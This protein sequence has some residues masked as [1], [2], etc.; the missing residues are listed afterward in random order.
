MTEDDQGVV[1]S[2]WKEAME[3]A[4]ANISKGLDQ[5]RMELDTSR[6][7]SSVP[8]ILCDDIRLDKSSE[9]G[10]SMSTEQEPESFETSVYYQIPHRELL[11]LAA[12]A[13]TVCNIFRFKQR[14]PRK[15]I[16]TPRSERSGNRAGGVNT[17][18]PN[19]GKLIPFEPQLLPLDV[20]GYDE[21]LESG[22]SMAKQGMKGLKH[23]QRIGVSQFPRH[24]M[25]QGGHRH[26]KGVFQSGPGGKATLSEAQQQL[27]KQNLKARSGSS[28]SNRWL[29]PKPTE[30][31]FSLGNIR[32][33]N[34]NAVASNDNT[35]SAASNKSLSQMVRELHLKKLGSPRSTDDVMN[36][37][38][39]EVSNFTFI[40]EE[41][42]NSLKSS[43][44]SKFFNNG[45]PNSNE[46][47]T[48]LHRLNEAMA[49]RYG[50]RPDEGNPA[51]ALPLFTELSDGPEDA[52][53]LQCWFEMGK[54]Y[55]FGYDSYYFWRK[56]DVVAAKALF[57][58]SAERDHAASLFYASFVY[59]MGNEP[60]SSPDHKKAA[61]Y[62]LRAAAL[63]YV[64]A[65]LA[66]AYRK[67]YG[68]GCVKD[69]GLA[70]SL[71][72]KVYRLKGRR[73]EALTYMTPMDD[74]RL[75]QRSTQAFK[76]S[77]SDTVQTEQSQRRE[78]LRYWE[79]K[80][81]VGDGLAMY[82]MGKLLEDDP[83]ADG[84]VAELYQH[85]SDKGIVPATRDLGLC[86]MHGI[87]VRQNAEK[88]VEHLTCAAEQGDHEAAKY[89]GYI[90]Y[91]GMDNP[92]EGNPV[93]RNV[94]LAMKY[95]TQAAKH[96]VPEAMYFM[97]EILSKRENTV[98]G[99]AV[100]KD[101][102]KALAM[103]SAAADYG[104]TH[105]LLREAEMLSSGIGAKQNLLRPALIYKVLSEEPFCVATMRDAFYSY[106]R[107]DYVVSFLYNA[108]A[109]FVGVQAAQL[110]MGQL[111]VDVNGV[112]KLDNATSMVRSALVQNFMQG[113][114]RSL[115][116]LGFIAENEGQ[117][118]VALE[119]YTKCFKGGDI[120]CL[121]PL[122]G[123]LSS[124][125]ATWG[126]A[127]A[128]LEY[129]Q[130]RRSRRGEGSGC[131]FDILGTWWKLNSLKARR[132]IARLTTRDSDSL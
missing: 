41:T 96:E 115:R 17:D 109:A 42:P 9:E 16:K 119:L 52:V 118:T 3:A 64:P 88:A 99:S 65:I 63:N 128:L 106:I 121:D 45:V 29:T 27:I 19:H 51:A 57:T 73:N 129:K 79:S 33:E 75:T 25:H 56:R 55:L 21:P 30:G 71:Y 31:I 7:C 122:V 91:R 10:Q 74:L 48:R 40:D 130:Y 6:Q 94:D 26:H 101:L 58:K 114:V 70:T 111:Y 107:K 110:N 124:E 127:I 116:L 61:A 34:A 69:V 11:A 82:E 113:D 22:E 35:P 117:R 76:L 20:A 37:S 46:D 95:F 67:L 8:R 53:T 112:K 32:G 15:A 97:G 92:E 2:G 1:F 38:T 126:K 72:K 85:A 105:A 104:L 123:L 23:D 62:L 83:S 50:S 59:S 77:L 131:T 36:M 120:E 49:V 132:A 84:R 100:H 13:N 28:T 78:A 80:A 86:Y 24:G 47:N 60:V 90:Y 98:L 87:G 18:D 4:R 108:L 125:R 44:F 68:I 43:Q 39:Q 54:I 81:S 14:S 93:K 103:Y 5:Y 89:L 12:C 66:L 102:Q